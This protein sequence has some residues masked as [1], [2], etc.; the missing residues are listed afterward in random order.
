MIARSNGIIPVTPLAD[1]TGKEGY[2]LLA[3]GAVCSAVT[4]IPLGVITEG[5]P[6]T[7]KDAVALCDGGLAGTVKVKLDGTPGTV[8]TGSYLQITATGTFKLDA[9]TGNRVLCAR[10]LEA[11]AANELIE[12]V[13]FKPTAL[14]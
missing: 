5:Q 13:L 14:S 12:A 7:G 10:A 4:D 1:H 6:T 3:T 2:A 11:G 9:G 8:V